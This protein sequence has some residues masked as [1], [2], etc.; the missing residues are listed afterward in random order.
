MSEMITYTYTVLRYVHDITT[1]EFLNVGV[2]LYAPQVPYTSAICRRTYG[3][4]SKVF[5][6]INADHFKSLMRHIEDRFDDLG[7]KLPLDPQANTVKDLAHRILPVDESA[8]QWSPM[9]SG[10]TADPAKTLES[11]FN[12]MVMRYEDKA[13]RVRRT[14]ADIWRHFKR[15]LETRQILQ[16]FEPRKIAVQDDE[17]EFQHTWENGLL[18]CLE[19]VSFDLNSPDSIKD[20][21][22]RWL[23]HVASISRTTT[24]FKLYFMVGEPQDEGLAPAFDKALS[25]LRKIP[26]ETLIFR[27]GQAEQMSELLEKQV[28]EHSL[29][30]RRV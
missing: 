22:H 7:G 3:R 25:I 19:P 5:P 2:A 20:K 27:E 12:R 23:G 30:S 29:S 18:H 4:L 8:L 14:E 28:A 17:I 10:R 24:E 1:G 16:H 15:T 13:V 26:V 6:S 9:G 21:A 11:L